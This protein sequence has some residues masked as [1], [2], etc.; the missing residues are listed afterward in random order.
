MLFIGNLARETGVDNLV[1]ML[2]G[3]EGFVE[4]NLAFHEETGCP[5]GWALATFN[6]PEQVNAVI[7]ELNCSIIHGRKIYLHHNIDLRDHNPT[8]NVY[9]G[10]LPFRGF[11]NANLDALLEGFESYFHLIQVKSGA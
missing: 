7:A 8:F 10:N 9:I 5:K 11:E 1:D 4:V 3:K 2:S 6:R